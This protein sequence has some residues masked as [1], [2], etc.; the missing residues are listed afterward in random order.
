MLGAVADARGTAL[1]MMVPAAWMAVAWTYAVAV[2]FVPSY[3]E[4]ADALGNSDIGMGRE[5][6]VG[7]VGTDE[8]KGSVN[9]N[10]Y[11]EHRELGGIDRLNEMEKRGEKTAPAGPL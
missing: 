5:E 2:N 1:A 3:R 10:G 4:P 8:E 9:G 11:A 7:S 6:R